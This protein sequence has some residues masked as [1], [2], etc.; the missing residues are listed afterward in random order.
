MPALPGHAAPPPPP[1]L[2]RATHGRRLRLARRVDARDRRFGTARRV[3]WAVAQEGEAPRVSAYGLRDKSAALPMTPDTL[4]RIY[5][6]TRAVSGV[7]LLRLIEEG[8]IALDAPVDRYIPQFADRRVFREMR[9]GQV[10]TVPAKTRMTVRH[11]LTYTS[12]YSSLPSTRAKSAS[13][14][15]AS[16]RSTRAS[17]RA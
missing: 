5:S 16:W 4:F 17:T 2:G 14:T 7:A 6:M 13:I 1:P 11:L 3:V 9:N 8:K 10:V 15:A 12:G